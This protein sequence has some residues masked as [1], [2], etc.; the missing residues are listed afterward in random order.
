MYDGVPCTADSSQC[1]YN[2]DM[3]C[4]SSNSSN[5]D[6][7]CERYDRGAYPIGDLPV[8]RGQMTDSLALAPFPNAVIFNWATIIIL[9]FGN[10]AALDFQARCMAAKSPR[11]ASLG[12][13]IGGLLTLFVGIPFSFLGSRIRYVFFF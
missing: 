12:C 8:Y 11:K 10:L 4:P 1:C 13:Y 5:W 6:G 7:I 2:I 3:W 9:A